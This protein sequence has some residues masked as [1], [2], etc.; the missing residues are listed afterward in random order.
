MISPVHVFRVLLFVA[1]SSGLSGLAGAQDFSRYRDFQ[2]GMDIDSV[3]RQA[4]LSLTE[5]RTVYQRPELVQTL[6]WRQYGFLPAATKSDS[7]QS[8]RFD[9]YNGALSK[10]VIGYDPLQIQGLTVDDLAQ[11]IS[12]VYGPPATPDAAVVISEPGANEE[13]RQTLARW[14]DADYAYSLFRAPYGNSFGIVAVAKK[15]DM[16]AVS[17]GREAVRLDRLEAPAIEA[18]RQK[19]AEETRLAAEEKARLA[20]KPNF[21]P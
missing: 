1:L 21:R 18:A 9:F 12:R 15:L 14:E 13:R 19:K 8:M 4:G 10:I 20:S 17:A 5:V 6:S 11:A 3:A 16:L 7:V 2:L